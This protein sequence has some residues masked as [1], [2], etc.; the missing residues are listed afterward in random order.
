M[1]SHP[2]NSSGE[3]YAFVQRKPSPV[4]NE[5]CGRDESNH[6]VID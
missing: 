6:V 3:Y 2:N 1:V 5:V 4:G